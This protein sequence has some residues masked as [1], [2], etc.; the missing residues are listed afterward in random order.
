M[1]TIHVFI[2]APTH[3]PTQT[4][5]QKKAHTNTNIY[6]FIF[7]DKSSFNILSVILLKY[8]SDAYDF[9]CHFINLWM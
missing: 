1:Q 2:Q 7:V 9:L 5:K 8:T 4:N 6:K 3:P